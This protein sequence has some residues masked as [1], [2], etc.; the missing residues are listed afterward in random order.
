MKRSEAT[1]LALIRAAER[2]FLARGSEQVSLREIAAAAGQRNPSATV[3]HFKDK[4]G[5]VEAL[6]ERHSNPIQEGWLRTLAG[7]DAPRTLHGLVELLVRTIVAK[8]DDADGGAAY[9]ALCTELVTSKTMP[10]TSMRVAS[11]EGASEISR[12]MMVLAPPHPPEL[13]L[14]RMMRV[15]SV[16]YTSV[17]D[18]A[19]L[20]AEGVPIEREGFV[21][22]LV[23]SVEALLSTRKTEETS[24]SE[25]TFP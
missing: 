8:L 11:G 6:L 10:L 14:L 18:F 7:P 2:L 24:S 5:L 16:L 17:S 4:R 23:D 20:T 15:A 3:Y 9:L 12:R 13:L 22:D 25:T 19:R 21:R 1:R